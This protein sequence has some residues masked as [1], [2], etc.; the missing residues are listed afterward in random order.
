MKVY[1]YEDE[2]FPYCYMEKK[3]ELPE[4]SNG[5]SEMTEE[6]YNLIQNF[7]NNV[8]KVQSY[9]FSLQDPTFLSPPERATLEK[10]VM[11]ILRN[12]PSITYPHSSR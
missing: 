2:R 10:Q 3:S 1:F 6:M 8:C 5:S 4:L 11:E 9:L 12:S 7:E